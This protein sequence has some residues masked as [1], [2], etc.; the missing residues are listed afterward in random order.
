[1]WGHGERRLRSIRLPLALLLSRE[2]RSGPWPLA[3]RSVVGVRARTPCGQPP[4]G[5]LPMVFRRRPLIGSSQLVGKV[6]GT[7][8]ANPIDHP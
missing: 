4:E 3:A 7:A 5:G 8:G 2:S 6:S 1:V